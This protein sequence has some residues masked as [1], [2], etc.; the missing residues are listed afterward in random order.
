VQK[1]TTILKSRIA[2]LQGEKERA[3]AERTAAMTAVGKNPAD[4][5]AHDRLSRSIAAVAQVGDVIE[6]LEKSLV[7]AG[8][9]DRADEL[10]EHRA[11]M[12][13]ARDRACEAAVARVKTAAKLDEQI[14]KLGATLAEFDEQTKAARRELTLA[15]AGTL[16][17][18]HAN[19]FD[20][21]LAHHALVPQML[22]GD[23]PEQFAIALKRAGLG[24]VGIET[25]GLI[26]YPVTTADMHAHFRRRTMR[27]AA[28]AAADSFACVLDN[29]H[30]YVGVIDKPQPDTHAVAQPGEASDE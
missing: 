26:E 11:D 18:D 13:A 29:Y 6:S 10:A 12:L 4:E 15:T 2:E 17:E 16:L 3:I 21:R 5:A 28:I 24:H 27:E 9:A 19:G 7:A 30:T 23:L 22:R 25:P 1:R 20:N 14:G 8:N